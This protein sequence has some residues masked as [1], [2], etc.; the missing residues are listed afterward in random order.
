MSGLGLSSVSQ[1]AHRR[2][3]TMANL[4]I[5]HS[6]AKRAASALIALPILVCA[7]VAARSGQAY[8]PGADPTLVRTDRGTLR[9]IAHDGVLEF[10]GIPYAVPPI[11]NLRWEPPE[12][13]PPWKGTL[14]ATRFGSGCPQVARYGLTEAGYDEDCL[15]LNVTEPDRRG[16]RAERERPVIVWIY[17]GAFVGGS[18][19]LYPLT[20]MATAGDAVV[21]SFN[22]LLGVFGFMAHPA[23]DPPS[24]GN[25][26]L[27]DQREALRWVKRN[28]GAFGGD[29]GNV[30]IAGESAG[31]ASVCMHILAPTETT[32]LFQKAIIQSAGCAQHLRTVEEVDQIGLKVAAL[33]GCSD[34][35][36]ALGCLR[37][38]PVK[39]LLE[40]AAR[41]SG[42]DVMTYAPSVG[43]EALPLQGA[44][45][46]A[47]GRFVH[48][49]IINGG[50]RDELRLYVAYD[51]Q[52]GRPVTP[53]NYLAHLK[54][55]YGDDAS[56]VEREY[57]LG[58]YSSAPSAFGTVMSDYTPGN[59]LN[60][61]VYL[62]TAQAASA[63]VKVYEY[64]FADRDAPPV[65]ADP[66]FEMGAVHSAELPYQF[67]GFSNTTKLDG[68]V[69]APSSQ[70]LANQMMDYWTSFARTGIP[71]A[72]DAPPW[73]SFSSG[74]D[75]M[76]LDPGKVGRF[77]ASGEH[78]CDFW[79]KLYPA[80]L[81]P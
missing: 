40:A 3:G 50:N 64:E 4:K 18:S 37:G 43:N 30:T 6:H 39:D 10:K 38:K 49:P 62:E 66:G 17:G 74:A 41:V 78:H 81:D 69:L 28:I 29:P 65:T 22:Y 55:V 1:D 70:R 68:P 27:E 76:R 16:D 48:V 56:S 11:G 61:C 59:G 9:G 79:R 73:I 67:P 53:S 58:G 35:A 31:A 47:T 2:A 36:T 7:S 5:F 23:F 42:G 46:M 26:A 54:A 12:T 15:F 33:I 72:A 60:N 63:F 52:A 44:E 51:V 77:D 80:A 8:G 19:S 45:A 14:D 34:Q 32:G 25:Y 21:V 13:F 57:P 75:V 24:N 20:H 71:K